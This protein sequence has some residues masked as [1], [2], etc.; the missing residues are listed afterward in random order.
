MTTNFEHCICM[1]EL[2]SII[3]AK[4]HKIDSDAVVL[5]LFPSLIVFAHSGTF[6]NQVWKIYV[7][8]N[9]YLDVFSVKPY[10]SLTVI[11]FFCKKIL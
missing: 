2:K 6:C 3:H 9:V 11:S 1:P 4:L 10:R 5:G 7:K 8:S